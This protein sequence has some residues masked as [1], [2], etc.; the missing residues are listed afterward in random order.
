LTADKNPRQRI[1]D[2]ALDIVE[3]QGIGA[4]TQPRIA[5][6][7][8]LRQSHLTYYFPRKADLFIALL[9]A[10][11]DRAEKKKKVRSKSKDSNAVFEY[12]AGLIFDRRRMQF[13]LGI[14]L[15]AS[16][17]P[18]LRAVLAAHA[19][20]LARRAAPSFGRREDDPAILAF[21]DILRG[22]GFRMLLE[23]DNVGKNNVDLEALAASFGL[24]RVDERR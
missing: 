17:E 3:T 5:K 15:A 6:A 18:E 20:E 23:P 21:I 1:L 14:V 8:G 2:A 4:L 10:S 19:G 9:D 24:H 13:F 11:H 22:M 12:L 16:E 7:T